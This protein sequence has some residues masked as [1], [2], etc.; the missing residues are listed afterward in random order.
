[1]RWSTRRFGNDWDDLPKV[2]DWDVF[3]DFDLQHR[4]GSS[5]R[6]PT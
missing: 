1:M 4:G 3:N 6:A 2:N 5:V